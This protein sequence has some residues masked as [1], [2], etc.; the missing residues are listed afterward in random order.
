MLCSLLKALPQNAPSSL[1]EIRLGNGQHAGGE[2][3][4]RTGGYTPGRIFDSKSG[5]SHF[6]LCRPFQKLFRRLHQL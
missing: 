5:K 2:P 3:G 6:L 4:R 1:E